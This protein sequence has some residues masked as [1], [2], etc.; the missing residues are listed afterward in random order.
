MKLWRVNI[1]IKIR[2]ILMCLMVLFFI[3]PCLLAQTQQ[4]IEE[5]R[6]VGNRRIPESTI[7]YYVQSQPNTIYREDLARRDYR[8]LLNTKFFEDA[9]LKTIQGELGIIVIFEV[10][11]RP[12]I[13]AIEFEGTDSFKESDILEKF[14]DM[15][16]GLSVDSP[17]D[18]SKLPKARKAIRVLLGQGGQP[19]GRVE[20]KTNRIAS[21]S[22]RIVFHIDA[23][24]KVRIGD[25]SFEGNTVFSDSELRNSLKMNKEKGLLTAFRNTDKYMEEKLEYDLHVNMLESYRSRGYIFAK[26]GTPDVSIVEAPRGLLLMF[27]KTKQQY[28]LSI[29]IEEG[30]QFRYGSFKIEGIENLDQELVEE[31]YN[32]VPGNIVDY[33][34]LKANNDELKK[35]YSILGYLDATVIPQV[36][37]DPEN[38]TVNITVQVEEGKQYIVDRIIFAGNTKSRDKVLRREFFVEEQA[39]FDGSLLDYSILRLNQLGFFD[40]IEEKDYEV[41]KRPDL[42]EVDIQ[43]NV[44]ERTQQSIGL[45][46]GISGISGS[47]FGINYQ[48]NNFRG[49]GQRIDIG[50]LTGT[51]TSNYQLSFT[52][53]YFR[54]SRMSFGMSVFKQHFRFDTYTAFFGMVSPDENIPLFTRSSL[55]FTLNSS[56]PL[57]RWSRFGIGYGLRNIGISDIDSMFKSFAENQLLGFTPGG[58]ASDKLVRSEVTPTFVYNTKNRVYN[59]TEGRQLTARVPFS[60][61]P[62][63]GGINIVRPQIEFQQF[64]P[65]RLISRGRH[66]FGFRAMVSHI[67][68]YGT[69]PG[70]IPMTVPFF[71]RVFLGGEFD[72]R[73]FDIRSVTPWAYTKTSSSTTKSLMPVGGDT[74][75]LVTGEYR[76]PL[77]GPLHVTAF[78]DLGTSTILRKNNLMLFGLDTS[79]ELLEASNNVLRVST[80]AEIQFLMP[81]INQPFRIILAYNPSRMKTNVTV[82]GKTYP[83]DEPS[84]N[85]KFT[86]GYNF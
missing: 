70:G 64:A 36:D 9:S 19:L 48:S 76:I 53:P 6:V 21:S 63:G 20:V 39:Q 57:G 11:E 45:T 10:K 23:G 86:V 1:Q 74:S 62:L 44:K 22:I 83:L 26:I 35:S 14:K 75:V 31:V 17:F 71:E 12:L 3:S 66:T 34:A 49:L 68:P 69:L 2:C 40:A 82:G 27:R 81:M 32:V 46:G 65:D 41:I 77:V 28:Y 50:I 59:A 15:K 7:L 18:P 67:I 42:G 52:E 16:V 78:I 79:I 51:R 56:Y 61:G 30:E 47:F 33:V 37:A 54:D 4:T 43:V 24:P 8:N 85:V 5:V 60:G 84:S 38:K 72:L 58:T 80:G 73:G 29:P 55:G 13:R 25:I